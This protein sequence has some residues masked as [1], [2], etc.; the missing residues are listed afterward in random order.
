VTKSEPRESRFYYQPITRTILRGYAVLGFIIWF[1]ITA[2]PHLD[3]GFRVLIGVGAFAYLYVAW[4]MGG[5]GLEARSD[6][7][8]FKRGFQWHFMAWSEIERFCIKRRS[9]SPTV[10]VDLVSGETRIVPFAQGR[11]T[12]WEGGK[13]R[14]TVAVL[15]SEIEQ[16]RGSSA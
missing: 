13:S 7:I 1:S 3:V 4:R 14:D 6:G 9:L 15:N 11:L 16:A 10:Y 2:A 8:R 12:R 5:R